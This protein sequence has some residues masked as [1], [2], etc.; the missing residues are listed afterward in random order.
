MR[1]RA[2]LFGLALLSAL[3][4][5]PAH[6]S[7]TLCNRTSY[8]LYAA[9]ASLSVPDIAI[10]GWTRIAPGACELA[11]KGDI[12]VEANYVYARTSRAHS[13]APRAWSGQIN[14]CVKDS[15]FTL[16]LPF[17]TRCPA[18]GYELPFAQVDT[19]HMRAWTT[20]FRETPD[21]PSMAAAERTGLIRLL[22]DLGVRGLGN[23][24]QLDAALA[25]F[26]KRLHLQDAAP[27]DA[28]FSALETEAMKIAVP[29][30]YT[31]CNDTDKPFWTAVGQQKGA[32]FS[33]KG[34]WTVAGGSCSH[35]ITD[36][37]AG[38]RVWL[39]VERSKG[40]PLVSGPMPFCVTNIEFDIQGRDN[41]AKRGLNETGFIE[42]NIKRL[43]G[44]TAHVTG[45][46]LA[47]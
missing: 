10:Q 27:A 5:S 36:S 23:D 20:T 45:T 21:L 40:S 30:G 33:S 14:L 34:W 18:D 22:G 6:A 13:A 15:S 7:L 41:C 12:S 35:L 24:K 17:G 28:L 4:L 37:I 3:V 38:G 26:R 43:P 1:P 31:V 11:V 19:H 47:K 39:R 8:V 25:Q 16:R 46:G 29:T 32:V 44:Y 2:T 42:T 9:T